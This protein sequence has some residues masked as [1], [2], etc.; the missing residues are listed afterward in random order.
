M[1]DL[2]VMILGALWEVL[3]VCLEDVVGF[4]GGHVWEVSEGVLAVL[5]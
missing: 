4:R 5:G 1:L 3:E 2:S